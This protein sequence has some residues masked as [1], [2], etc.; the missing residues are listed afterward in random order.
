MKTFF[1]KHLNR[2]MIEDGLAPFSSDLCKSL[3]IKIPKTSDQKLESTGRK[4]PTLFKHQK[5]IEYDFHKT[6]RLLP[7]MVFKSTLE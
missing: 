7:K 5:S 2:H 6:E 3:G 1:A 4:T